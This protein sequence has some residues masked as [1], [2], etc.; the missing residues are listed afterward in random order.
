MLLDAVLTAELQRLEAE[1]AGPLERLVAQRSLVRY[2]KQGPF[3]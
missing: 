3:L 2:E 1:P